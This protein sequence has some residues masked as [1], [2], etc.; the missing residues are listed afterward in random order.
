[1]RRSSLIGEA[2]HG[3]H[4][5]YR[6]RVELS[7]R[8]IAEKDFTAVCIEGDWPDAYWVNRYV[9]GANDDAEAVDALA[10]F[11]RFPT[12]MLWRNA[13]VL[14][15]VGW[16]REYYGK[17]A[18]PRGNDVDGHSLSGFGLYRLGPNDEH[19]NLGLAKHDLGNAAQQEVLESTPAVR[20]HYDEIG[21]ESLGIA[22]NFKGRGAVTH[23]AAGYYACM[24]CAF[25]C[26]GDA[27]ARLG[28]HLTKE[29]IHCGTRRRRS[30]DGDRI[31]NRANAEFGMFGLRQLQ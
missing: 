1:M 26:I 8:L 4:E 17:A 25:D 23:L 5:F 29:R 13:D 22:E 14:D 16:L 2:T 7:K 10:G 30:S 11:T 19:R 31:D 20:S 21:A 6:A 18:T 12:W 24:V 15:F 28:F 27:A 3:T 9:R